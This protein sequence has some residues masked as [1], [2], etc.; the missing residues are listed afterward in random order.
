MFIRAK[1]RGAR[2]YLQIVENRREGKKVVQTVRATLGRLDVLVSTGKLD[3]LLRSGLRFSEKLR[4][5]DAHSRDECTTTDT[6]RVG[7]L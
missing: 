3:S 2:T 4:V 1:K 6:S 5:L 7:G